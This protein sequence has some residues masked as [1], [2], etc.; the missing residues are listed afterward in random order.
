MKYNEIEFEAIIA[1][2]GCGKSYLS[3]KYPEIFADMDEI[4]LK[5]K[6]DI[7]D[8]ISREELEI[9][10]G[11]RS[12]KKK[13]YTI[14]ELYSLYDICLKQGKILLAA[15][16]GES[17]NY[18]KIRNIKFCFVYPKKD[19]KD[20]MLNRF[21]K[22]KNSQNFIEETINKFDEFY[23][24]NKKDTRAAVHYETSKGEY[25]EEIVRKFGLTI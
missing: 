5:C 20:E 3:D 13:N 7:P 23:E 18:F 8:D 22:R 14:N 9:S 1:A 11:N 15:P 2:P 10:K 6:Y 21:N 16:H 12:F 4:R 25:L 19:L 17:F 24:L